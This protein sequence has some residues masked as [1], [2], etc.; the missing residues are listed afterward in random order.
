MLE[1]A[2]LRGTVAVYRDVATDQTIMDYVPCKPDPNDP[3]LLGANP[4]NDPKTSTLNLKQGTRVIVDLTTVSH[5]PA[6]FPDP[7]QVKLDRSLDSYMHYGWGPHQCLGME[8]SRV[9]M[10]AMFK[11]VVGLKG[12]KKVDGPRGELKSFPASVWSGQVGR[13]AVHEWSGLRA[14]MTADQS[15]YWPMPTTLKVRYDD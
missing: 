6:I 7:E 1:G 3:T 4:V 14:Y 9:V 15:S 11:A 5:D 10:T 12:L 13:E 8:I 2:R